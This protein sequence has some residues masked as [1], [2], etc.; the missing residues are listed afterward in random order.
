M[1][2]RAG[3]SFCCY[4]GKDRTGMIAAL[5]LANAG[6]AA[7]GV[8]DYAA[9][10]A[11]LWPEYEQSLQQGASGA[12]RIWSKPWAAPATMHAFLAHLDATA[13]AACAYLAQAGMRADAIVQIHGRLRG[14]CSRG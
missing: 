14:N 10:Q 11:R 5:L 2:R 13:M 7:D 4:G 6:V 3:W 9:S 1:R 12:A 8:K